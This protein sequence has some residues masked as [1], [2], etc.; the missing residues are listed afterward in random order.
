MHRSKRN[1][2]QILVLMVLISTIALCS[3]AY[4][5]EQNEDWPTSVVEKKAEIEAKQLERMDTDDDGYISEE[6]RESY[7]QKSKE[8]RGKNPHAP[9]VDQGVE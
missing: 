2:W 6:E 8:R 9:K 7:K 1:R 4:A 3:V 5:Q